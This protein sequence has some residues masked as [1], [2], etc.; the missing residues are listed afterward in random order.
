VCKE[1]TMFTIVVKDRSAGYIVVSSGRR[2][3]L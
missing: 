2:R 1:G 3:L